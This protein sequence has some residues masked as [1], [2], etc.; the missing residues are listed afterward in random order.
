MD[1]KVSPRKIFIILLSVIGFLLFAHLMGIVSKYG[2]GHGTVYG[3]V[4]LFDLK[5]GSTRIS[6]GKSRI[7]PSVIH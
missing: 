2:F 3:L 4:A 6:V 1:I 7:R 5:R